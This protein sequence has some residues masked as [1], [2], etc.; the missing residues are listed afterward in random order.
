MNKIKL[1][2]LLIGLIGIC[3]I[4]YHSLLIALGTWL[5]IWGNNI[6]QTTIR[7][8]EIKELISNIKKGKYG[9]E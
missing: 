5:L 3:I 8:E 6:E 4:A 9:Q 1:L 2:G 7:L